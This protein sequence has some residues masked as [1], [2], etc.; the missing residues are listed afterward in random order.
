MM[1]S[2]VVP[3][4]NEAHRIPASLERIFAYMDRGHADFEVVVVDD[5]STDGTA[6]L[7]A[8]QFGHR[9]QLRVLVYPENHGKGYA[10]RRGILA[11]HGEL[12]I[13][14]DADLSTPIEEV[15][16]LLASL[17]AGYDLVIGSRGLEE[18]EVRQR[19]PFYRE[20][21][22]KLFN[23]LVRCF[24]VPAF[25]DTQCGFKALRREALLPV[26]ERLEIDGFAFD[27]ELI[28][29]AV[30]AGIRVAEVPVIWINSPS[31]RV[32]MSQGLAAFIDLMRIRRR[33]RAVGAA[34]VAAPEGH[35]L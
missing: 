28:A 14:S 27:V 30:A 8:Q 31:S 12:V 20:R 23:V 13:V 3:A 2:I 22:G 15:E 26:V 6:D 7:V 21:A 35:Q 32:R 18:S 4:Y 33:A 34:I 16:K 29:M 1:L 9:P 24:V 17:A 25:Y 19:Q 11:A 5:G 10:V